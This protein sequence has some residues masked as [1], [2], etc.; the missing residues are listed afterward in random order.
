MTQEES[1][2]DKG[3]PGDLIPVCAKQC[4]GNLGH[5]QGHHGEVFPEILLPLRLFKCHE[6]IWLV[7]PG[8]LDETPTQLLEKTPCK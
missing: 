4:L 6:W 5:W 3:K 1:G 7:V 8:L 2:G